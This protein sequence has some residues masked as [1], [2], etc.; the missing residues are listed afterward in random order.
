MLDT[1]GEGHVVAGILVERTIGNGIRARQGILTAKLIERGVYFLDTA[2]ILRD[3]DIAKLLDTAVG[4]ELLYLDASYARLGVSTC[5]P[6]AV[7][8]AEC[9]FRKA[10]G[11]VLEVDHWDGVQHIVMVEP[12]MP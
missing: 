8:E 10:V 3:V 4:R 7:S 12:Q 5:F 9:L 11:F 6:L 2:G 1:I